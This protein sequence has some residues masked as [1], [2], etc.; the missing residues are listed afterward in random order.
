M[1][2]IKKPK[3]Q[4]EK[5]YVEK[6]EKVASAFCKLATAIRHLHEKDK[7]VNYGH[8]GDLGRMEMAINDI[9]EWAK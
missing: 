2:T 6:S 9:L 8:V 5:D 1:K 7:V 4:V 3:T